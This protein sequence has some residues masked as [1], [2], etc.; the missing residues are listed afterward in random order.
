M[1][2][3]SDL[4]FLDPLVTA[5]SGDVDRIKIQVQRHGAEG[6]VSL[7][8]GV[9]LEDAKDNAIWFT[10]N[11]CEWHDFVDFGRSRKDP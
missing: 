2:I 3:F 8:V 5:I 1:S 10:K 11:W 9:S 7:L 4:S 6:N